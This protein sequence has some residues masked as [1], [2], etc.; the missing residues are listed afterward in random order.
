[1]DDG[2]LLR[3]RALLAGRADVTEKPM[4]G[5][6]SFLLDGRLWCG[7]TSGG[8]LVRVGKAGMAAALAEPHVVAHVLGGRPTGAFVVVAAEAVAAEADLVRWVRRG[9]AA[10][11]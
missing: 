9:E 7:V 4:V 1:M 8:L 11:R 3:L 5:G 6:R 10:V 2:L